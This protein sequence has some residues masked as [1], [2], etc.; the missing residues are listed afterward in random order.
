[1]NR[2]GKNTVFLLLLA[3]WAGGMT[4]YGQDTVRVL[5]AGD[6]MQH[7]PQLL[8]AAADSGR[9]DYSESFRYV[10]PGI[11]RAD[12]AIANLE[13]PLGAPPYSGYPRFSAPPAFARAARDA[14][15]D[16]LVTANNHSLDQYKRGVVRTVE[17]LDSLGIPHTGVF[18]D[19]AER[20]ERYPLLFHRGGLRFALLDYTYG[21]NGIP[22]RPPTFVNRI[23]TAQI[24]TDL[25]QARAL[26]PDFVLVCIHWGQEYRMLPDDAQKAL[27]VFLM[28]NGADV[29]IGS[30]PHVVQPMHALR[31]STG[32]IRHVL[33]YSLGNYLSNQRTVDTQGGATITV[34]FVRDGLGKA[35]IAGCSYA[36]VWMWKPVDAASARQHFYILPVPEAQ[37]GDF[38]LSAEEKSRLDA[39]AR[40]A[41]DLFSRH[42]TDVPEE[43]RP[44]ETA[45]ATGK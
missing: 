33:A 22:H 10:A 25:A 42:N 1:M 12:I 30:H 13:T 4:A 7:E 5:F 43:K 36:L 31:D 15:F 14:G 6:L 17:V 26:Q 21:T 23:D 20:R 34:D 32:R 24:R 11:K 18:R 28:D 45:A 2:I 27:G 40:H 9:Y 29:V 3:L 37:R 16:V 38:P 41:R 39:F 8:S 19:T 35:R 44:E